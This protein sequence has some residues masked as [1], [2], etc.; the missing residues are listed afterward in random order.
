MSTSLLA[1]YVLQMLRQLLKRATDGNTKTE[2]E[3]K[4][5]RRARYSNGI[6]PLHRPREPQESVNDDKPDGNER[7]REPRRRFRLPTAWIS[8][9]GAIP[10][11]ETTREMLSPG[12]G[13]LKTSQA[14][15]GTNAAGSLPKSRNTPQ[16]STPPPPPFNQVDE[17]R[18]PPASSLVRS[19]T[20]ER[21]RH[22][23]APEAC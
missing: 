20:P 2:S 18:F 21:L 16:V 14:R 19:R 1:C 22:P 3:T 6:Y 15:R 10:D 23:S 13:G 12:S 7:N 17:L 4:S 9:Q 11:V 5:K 8:Q